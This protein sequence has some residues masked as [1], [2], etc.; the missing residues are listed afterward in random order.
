VLRHA[1]LPLDPKNAI[2]KTKRSVKPCVGG[3]LVKTQSEK[4][5]GSPASTVTASFGLMADVGLKNEK[6]HQEGPIW[7]LLQYWSVTAVHKSFSGRSHQ[8]FKGHTI[9]G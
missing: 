2:R 6:R 9:F 8:R 5:F 3:Y 7:R 4:G 1:I